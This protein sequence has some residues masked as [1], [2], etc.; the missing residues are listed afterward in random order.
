MK[1]FSKKLLGYEKVSS[2]IPWATNYILNVHSLISFQVST[3]LAKDSKVISKIDCRRYY[4][5]E[6]AGKS[7]F[8]LSDEINQICRCVEESFTWR[9]SKQTLDI[10]G[11]S[12]EHFD[13]SANFFKR[14]LSN[15][16]DHLLNDCIGISFNPPHPKWQECIYRKIMKSF[17]TLESFC[18]HNMK[19][20]LLQIMSA[21]A[22]Q[23]LSQNETSVSKLGRTHA[24]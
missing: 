17:D 2:M 3:V 1:L 9:L 11:L 19:Q 14:T 18:Y 15:I 16:F 7:K 24:A 21:N 8:L 20:F 12:F 23:I 4:L 22:R 5:G 6:V 10:S 13:P